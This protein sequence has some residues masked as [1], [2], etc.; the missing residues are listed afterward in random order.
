VFY[1][2]KLKGNYMENLNEYNNIEID[3]LQGVHEL[4][5]QEIDAISGGS[6]PGFIVSE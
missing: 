2:L 6:R 1:E 3:D 5:D 4:T